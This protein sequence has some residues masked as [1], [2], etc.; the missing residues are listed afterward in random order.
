MLSPKQLFRGNLSNGPTG[1][2][3]VFFQKGIIQVQTESGGRRC[4][5]G[6]QRDKKDESDEETQ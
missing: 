2:G 3:L 1:G 6:K 4:K 5:T